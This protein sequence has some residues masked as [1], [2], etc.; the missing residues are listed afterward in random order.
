MEPTRL[1]AIISWVSLP[2]VMYGGYAL[3]NLTL[4][5]RLNPAQERSFR[6][7][8]A[9]A[10]VLILLSLLYTNALAQTTLSR[11]LQWVL[12]DALLAG[13][14]AQSGGFFLHM[15]LGKPG[16]RSVGTT[17][18]TV[19]ALLLAVAILTLAYGLVIA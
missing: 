6:A 10:G 9:H 5:G 7:G 19:G 8:H 16:E 2:T 18:T 17:V 15:A 11:G 4:R 1:F 12:C 13:V 3:L 14:L